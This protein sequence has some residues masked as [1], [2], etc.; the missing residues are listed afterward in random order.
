MN[1]SPVDVD[2]A[3]AP[4]DA[5]LQGLTTSEAE[6]RLEQ[7]GP[8]DPAPVRRA[9]AVIELLLLFLNPLVVLLLVSSFV[10]FLL[11]D[12]TSATIILAIVLVGV[13]I[14]FAQT[15]RS[16]KAI[17]KLREIVTP[18]ATVLHDG[19]WQEI[20]RH[21]I[22]PGD[23]VRLSASDLIPADGRLVEPRDLYVQ[24]AALT[25]ESLPSEK[26][27]RGP[28]R[29]GAS[30]SESPNLVLMGTSVVS[31]TFLAIST[32]EIA[33]RLLFSRAEI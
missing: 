9:A 30:K 22:V 13:S 8:N 16:E 18:T 27:A 32:V 28:A 19:K 11:G 31:E 12:R 3:A 1:S 33:K 4:V 5:A 17:E 7:Y 20:K 26:D 21:E 6:K 14:N 23:V 25:G 24:Q 29:D 15:Y 10:S 2:P